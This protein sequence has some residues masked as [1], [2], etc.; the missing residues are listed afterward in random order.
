MP[1]FRPL[2]SV[3]IFFFFL[4]L[5]TTTKKRKLN[6]TSCYNID[7]DVKRKEADSCKYS[8][9]HAVAEKRS[10]FLFLF[11]FFFINTLSGHYWSHFTTTAKVF[12]VPPLHFYCYFL[13]TSSDFHVSA[14][15][16]IYFF[17]TS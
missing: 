15:I 9:T 4:T 3:E 2:L 14:D 1:L 6:L 16:F 12:S 10:Y 17:R 13:E 8:C 7:T 11:S 5:K